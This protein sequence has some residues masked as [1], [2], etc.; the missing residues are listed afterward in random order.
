MIG[1]QN[2]TKKNLQKFIIF[3]LMKILSIIVII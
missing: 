1:T 2:K 3:S